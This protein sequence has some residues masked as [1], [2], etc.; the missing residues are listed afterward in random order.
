[1]IDDTDQAGPIGQRSDQ[2]CT[3]TK[4]VDSTIS[5]KPLVVVYWNVAG[6]AVGNIDAFFDDMDED[7]M[8]DAPI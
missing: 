5:A 2:S 6:I 3:E 7:V 4:G 8:W 1:M